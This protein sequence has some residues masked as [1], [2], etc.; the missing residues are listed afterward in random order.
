MANIH[1]TCVVNQTPVLIYMYIMFYG[2]RYIYL[3][4]MP[5]IFAIVSVFSEM[6][7]VYVKVFV[8]NVLESDF[9]QRI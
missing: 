7:Y 8:R 2:R 5:L 3:S 9:I 1:F 6:M 4:N